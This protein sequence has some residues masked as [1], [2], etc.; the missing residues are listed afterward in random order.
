MLHTHIVLQ[1]RIH[2]S[3]L[4]SSSLLLVLSILAFFPVA[5]SFSDTLA[6]PVQSETT[7]SMTA[8]NINLDLSVDNPNG[9]FNA[10]D[11]AS[12][13]VATNNYTGYTLSI[14]ASTSGNDATKLVNGEDSITSISTASS[15]NDFNNGNWG[16]L[17]S[18][19]NSAANSSYIPAPTSEG[20]TLDATNSANADANSY[21][22]ALGA[23]ADYTLPAGKYSNT[24]VITAVA[25]PVGYSITYDKNTTDTVSGMPGTQ[26]GDVADTDVTISDAEPTRANYIFNNWCDG[27][28][29]VGTVDTCDGNVYEPGDIYN[30][31]QTSVNTLNLKALWI[32]DDFY[33]VYFDAN[34]G[35]GTMD[36]LKI[37]YGSSATIG[38]NTYTKDGAEFWEWNTDPTA[39]G[40]WYDEGDTFTAPADKSKGT[41]ITL[42]ADWNSYYG[43][44][45]VPDNT[46]TANTTFADAFQAAYTENGK[47]I[48]V[49]NT[50]DNLYHEKLPGETVPSGTDVR[51]AMQDINMTFND[52]GTTR[53]VCDA[54]SV[55]DDSYQAVD[56]R[57]G[58]L[59][60]ILKTRNG[61][62]WMTQN[63]DLDLSTSVTLTSENTDLNTTGGIYT[64]GYSESNGVISWT[65]SN[66]TTV[67]AS[68]SISD[69]N[70]IN[71]P[72]STDVGDW[73]Q[74]DQWFNSAQKNFMSG[75]QGDTFSTT[76][77]SGNGTH[78]HV[79]NYYNWPAA[80]ASND[81]SAMAAD[82]DSYED[83]IYDAENSVCPAGWELPKSDRMNEVHNTYTRTS[84]VKYFWDDYNICTGEFSKYYPSCAYNNDFQ[85]LNHHYNDHD[86]YDSNGLE[87]SELHLVRAGTVS[88]GALKNVGY[89]GYYW[90]GQRKEKSTYETEIESLSSFYRS[91]GFDGS[92]KASTSKQRSIR[93]M[94][95]SA[96]EP[97]E[98]PQYTLIHFCKSNSP[99]YDSTYFQLGKQGGTI[100]L[101]P[102]T[103]GGYSICSTTNEQ[104]KAFIGWNTEEDGS[105]TF[106]AN[107]ASFTIPNNVK[108]ITLYPVYATE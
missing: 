26:T 69:S 84:T 106:Y 38:T 98:A 94:A 43:G 61:K 90:T 101:R 107:Q 16:I 70:N 103:S 30:M 92:D 57:D 34:G 66:T 73:Y 50:N 93:C 71:N 13:T 64:N 12:L 24:F 59:Y 72:R 42:Y 75:T 2:I 80:I 91:G 36:P 51:Y 21:T 47:G 62:C 49:K 32:Y 68:A 27:T 58:K 48:Y 87:N 65:P 23:K 5:S 28:V 52:N 39:R 102:I 108:R 4:I 40:D 46:Y 82:V 88:K 78:G 54:V 76:P 31:S 17:P 44:E 8:E 97:T 7:L 55:I 53:S 6:A 15:A 83:Y 89:D 79:G 74:T 95:K 77:Y 37:P 60:W 11:P 86:M 41:S 100:T 67:A 18:K 81:I 1:K 22:I 25:N 35:T 10:S 14:L 96:S 3:A 99:T 29:T 56:I 85:I 33:T 63:L 105:G 9:T 19:V 104:G 45:F 20:T